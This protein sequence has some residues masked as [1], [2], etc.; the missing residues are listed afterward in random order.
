MS[1]YLQQTA[2]WLDTELVS[3]C[4][5]ILNRSTSYSLN[6][7]DQDRSQFWRKLIKMKLHFNYITA[8][9]FHLL[10]PHLTHTKVTLILKQSSAAVRG[11]KDHMRGQVLRSTDNQHIPR[12]QS[13]TLDRAWRTARASSSQETAGAGAPETNTLHAA[14]V[15]AWV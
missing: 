10:N 6:Y 5:G 9:Q 15:R 7:K 4:M 12:P 3:L 8:Y 11:G 2:L 14:S 13:P 1:L